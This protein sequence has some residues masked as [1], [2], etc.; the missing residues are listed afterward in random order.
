MSLHASEAARV[1]AAV[2]LEQADQLDSD[3]LEVV[4]PAMVGVRTAARDLA[5]ALHERGWGPGVL[6]PLVGFPGDWEDEDLDELDDDDDDDFGD[7]DD[8]DDPE[9]PSGQR[10]TY[11][12]RHD[13]VVSDPDR[14]FAYLVARLEAAGKGTWTRDDILGHGPLLVLAELD[15]FAEQSYEEHGLVYGGGQDSETEIVQTLWEMRDGR[16]DQYP[17]SI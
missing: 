15:G 6:F 12:A 3:D 11:Q 14:F 2:L 5:D 16:D 7:D 17:V 8:G 9:L 10:R 4:A 1:L 13:F